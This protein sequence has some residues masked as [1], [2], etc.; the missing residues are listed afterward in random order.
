MN[1]IFKIQGAPYGCELPFVD[2]GLLVPH[3]L[4]IFGI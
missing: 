3:A 4:E 2:I 1:A